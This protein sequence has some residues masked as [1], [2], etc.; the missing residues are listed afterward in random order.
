M[1]FDYYQQIWSLHLGLKKTIFI[2]SSTVIVTLRQDSLHVDKANFHKQRVT[3]PTIIQN[4]SH[5]VHHG[6]YTIIETRTSIL[7]P[8]KY[9]NIEVSVKN[10]FC[11]KHKNMAIRL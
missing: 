9:S 11:C 4:T 1:A 2:S 6:G 8:A 3:I 7:Y 5:S 10:R